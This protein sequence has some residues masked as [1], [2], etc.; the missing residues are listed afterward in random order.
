M[1]HVPRNRRGEFSAWTGDRGDAV[2]LLDVLERRAE[3][4]GFLV[5]MMVAG[6][7]RS[8]RRRRGHTWSR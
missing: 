3:V 1:E 5:D 6:R 7:V 8:H 4:F 2:L